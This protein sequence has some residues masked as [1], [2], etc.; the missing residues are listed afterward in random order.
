MRGDALLASYVYER[1]P[2]HVFR[3]ALADLEAL[4]RAQLYLADSASS[5]GEFDFAAAGAGRRELRAIRTQSR[6]AVEEIRA[7]RRVAVEPE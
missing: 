5:T 1:G 3:L 7:R 4:E 6:P 2:R